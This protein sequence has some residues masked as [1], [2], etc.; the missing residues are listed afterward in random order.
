MLNIAGQ[1][2][3]LSGG[4]L[5]GEDEVSRFDM[6]E[7]LKINIDFQTETA[8]IELIKID[9]FP[10]TRISSGTMSFMTDK[11]SCQITT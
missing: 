8:T 4:S 11:V 6:S 7:I 5:Y 10:I 9:C 1:R 2:I 3:F